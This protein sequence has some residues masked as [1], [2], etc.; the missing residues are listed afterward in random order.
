MISVEEAK[1]IIRQNIPSAQP[2]QLP[3]TDA[4]GLILAEDLYAKADIPGYAQ[5]SMDGYAFI[6]SQR[7]KALSITG[8]MAAGT[9]NRLTISP[10]EAA[11]IFTGAPLPLGADTVVMQEKTL[12]ENGRLTINDEQLKLGSNVRQQGAEIQKGEMAMPAKTYMSVAAA[13]FLAG[14]GVTTVSVYPPP[15]VTIILTGNEIRPAGTDLKFGEV[16]D[17][18]SVMLKLALMQAGVKEISNL[19][20]DDNLQSVQRTIETALAQSDMVLL[21]GGVS[22]GDYDYVVKS[23]EK[24]GV[25]KKFHRIR[26]KPG[27]PLYFGTK[28]NKLIFGLP[29]N[30]SSALT[31]FYIYVLPAIEAM[32]QKPYS[33]KEVTGTLTQDYVKPKG[34][35]H[36]LKATYS[37]GKVTPLHAQ[38]SFRLHSFAQAN[39]LA[40]LEEDR[41]QYLAGEKIRVNILPV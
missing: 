32:M 4:C 9:E 26:Q 14:I 8:E 38:E 28:G 31:C 34:L 39:C 15:K 17:S 22:V 13:G 36:F 33:E 41:D 18:N 1:Q 3:L 5:S 10:D 30:P 40:I 24:C 25:E 20:A 21:T 35:T 16:Y 2:V 12:A 7:N 37:E 29:G 23:A 27:K 6:F 11:R 19:N